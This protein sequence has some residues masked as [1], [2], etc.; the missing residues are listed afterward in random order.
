MLEIK[1]LIIKKIANDQILV[2]KLSFVL[3]KNSKYALIGLEGNG[4]ST[5]LK[6]I[7][8]SD[9]LNYVDV[10]GTIKKNGYS[11]GYLPQII[12]D[13]WENEDIID[14]L[15]KGSPSSFVNPDDYQKL[16][17]LDRILNQVNFDPKEFDDQKK[18]NQFSGG[19]VVKL[20]LVKILLNDPDILLLDEPTNDLDLETIL[21]LEEFILNE[22]KP[23]LFISH[24]EAL[25][26][27]TANGIIHLVKNNKTKKAFTYFE[28][29]SYKE[30]KLKR[31]LNL[32][33]DEMKAKKQRSNFKKKMDRFKQIYQKVEHRQNQVVRDPTQG[34]LLAKKIKS[35]KST[36]SRYLREQDDFLDFPVREEEINLFFDSRIKVPNN[37]IILNYKLSELK[38]ED[39]L[40]AR[41]V[42]LFVKGPEKIA[43]IG[44]NGS[45]KTTLL[46]NIIDYL[47]INTNL[48]IGYM[49]QNYDDELVNDRNVID[50]LLVEP[51]RYPEKRIRELLGSLSF[52]REEMTCFPKNLSGGQKAKI[53]LLKLVISEVEVLVLDEPTRN[54]SPLS[55]PIIHNMLLKYNGAIISVT[56]DRNFIENVFDKVYIL[57]KD[58]LFKL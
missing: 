16:A 35:L 28:K 49:S 8:E 39:N 4:K 44:K 36:E 27:N 58:G 50:N 14:F 46:R 3:N 5:L 42:E 21:F 19:E 9:N 57:Q 2:N 32:D 29:L 22:T 26:E 12:K 10:E 6:V 11:I 33:S 1:N 56:H 45:G 52:T 15:I 31:R 30:Y 51:D 41:N 38:I 54:L 55:I 47:R 40:L 43:I 25:L 17:I 34:R 13:D 7:T 23:I 48:K 37:K 24:D 18:M 53:L 20:G